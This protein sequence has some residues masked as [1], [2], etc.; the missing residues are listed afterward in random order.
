M[1]RWVYPDLSY[2]AKRC[3]VRL[4]FP[5]NHTRPDYEPLLVGSIGRLAGILREEFTDLLVDRD[6]ML[7]RLATSVMRRRQAAAA[8][9][10]LS[11]VRPKAQRAFKAGEWQRVIDLYTPLRDFIK[12]SERMRIDYARRR[13]AEEQDE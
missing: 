3:Y 2:E 5:L 13:L 10:E 4:A 12:G 1:A 9:L 11:W 7:D 8:D 6:G